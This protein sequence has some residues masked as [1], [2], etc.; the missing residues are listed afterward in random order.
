M[1]DRLFSGRFILTFTLLAASMFVQAS[2]I[3]F[4]VDGI[5]YKLEEGKT[6]VSVTFGTEDNVKYSGDVVI[7]PTVTYNGTT[8]NVTYIYYNAFRDCPTL[9][10]VTM[11]ESVTIIEGSAFQGCT[12]L[13]SI[14][15]PEYVTTIEDYAFKYCI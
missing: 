3:K 8:Y 9:T 7:P 14:T 1:N 13:T 12:G 10:S 5:Y 11:P 15:I 2:D 4:M 6:T